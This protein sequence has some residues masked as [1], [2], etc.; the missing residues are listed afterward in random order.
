MVSNVI[1]NLNAPVPAAE[2]LEV[3]EKFDQFVGESLF[4]QML[5]SMRKTLDKPA[6]FHGGRGEEVFQSQLDQL[7]VQKLSEASA[8]ELSGPMFEQFMSQA[9]LSAEPNSSA[10]ST[11]STQRPPHWKQVSLLQAVQTLNDQQSAP[12]LDALA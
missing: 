1:A 11:E 8:Q 3:R 6:Y 12:L 9:N 2:Q 5:K 10:S 7:L 4:G